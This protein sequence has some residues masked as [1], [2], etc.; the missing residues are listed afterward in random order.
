MI[1][2]KRYLAQIVIEADSPLKIGSGDKDL[3]LDSPIQKDWNGLPMILGT[4][5]T[6][7][8]RH[9]FNLNPAT[10][11]GSYENDKSKDDKSFLNQLFGYQDKNNDKGL[12]SR[13][14]VSNAHLLDE[15]MRVNEGLLLEKSSFLKAFDNLPVREHTAIT[16]KGV[17]K[18]HSKFDEEVIFKG[19]RFKFE[20]ELIGDTLNKD[21]E[22]ITIEEHEENDN[23]YKNNWEEIIN[24]LNSPI[25]RLGGGTT[26]GFGKIKVISI[27]EKVYDLSKDEDI[28]A[29]QNK[30]ASLNV[31]VGASAYPEMK[32]AK[33]YSRY[34]LKITPDD[35]FLFG[36]GFADDEADMTP[37]KED[38][39][40][41]D[42]NKGKFS[43]QQILMP[44]TSIKGAL[45]HRTAFY[46]N[47]LVGNF[48]DKVE[49][50]NDYIMENNKAVSEIFGIAKDSPKEN[51]NRSLEHN[52]KYL[53]LDKVSGAKGK[54]LISDMFKVLGKNQEKVFDHVKIDRFTGGAM[55]GALFQEKV[56]AQK[57]E[58]DIEILLKKDEIND[59]NVIKAFELALRDITTGMLPL[60]GSVMKGH[61][62]FE[63]KLYKNGVEI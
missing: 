53:K 6:G 24:K 33:G 10:E 5:I 38:V 14:I 9:S 11:N 51:F 31:G 61:G 12:G 45:S 41:W 29:Y 57:D 3:F 28:K 47:K 21:D 15:D 62:V 46:Y 7:V 27:Q 37:V 40:L 17:A 63:G 34:N 48:A 55:D 35:F 60:G 22:N 58:W 19:T 1:N 25:F 52:K 32:G 20:I 42:N 54:I 18:E 36:S 26:K 59:E 8:L 43:K 44:A 2:Q 50:K 23:K 56:V 49:N 13:L 4:S 39:I 30:S 16:D